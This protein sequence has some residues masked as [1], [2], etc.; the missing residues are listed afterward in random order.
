MTVEDLIKKLEKLPKDKVVT[1]TDP[2][3]IGWDNIGKVV[4][5]IGTVRI[6]IDGHGIFQ[7][8]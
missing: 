5:G 3:E 4:N 1:I 7:E 6:V 2:K 8:N